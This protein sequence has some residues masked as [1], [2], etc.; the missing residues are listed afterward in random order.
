MVFNLKVP[1][2]VTSQEPLW[3]QAISSDFHELSL[4]SCPQVCSVCTSYLLWW[5]SFLRSFHLCLHIGILVCTLMWCYPSYLLFLVPILFSTYILS[6]TMLLFLL[7]LLLFLL[8]LLSLLLLFCC[9]TWNLLS[10]HNLHVSPRSRFLRKIFVPH[11][12]KTSAGQIF[13]LKIW[14]VYFLWNTF[15][16]HCIRWVVFRI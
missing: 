4:F 16:K 8:L 15:P 2:L 12:P 5:I 3:C 10:T 13:S 14:S 1:A 7:L 9:F 6:F 11:W